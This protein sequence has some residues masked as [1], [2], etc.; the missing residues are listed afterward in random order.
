MRQTW[1]IRWI[2]RIWRIRRTRRIRRIQWIRRIA[3]A[4]FFKGFL[5]FIYS[6]TKIYYQVLT[7]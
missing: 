1:R 2:Q 4:I 6:A 3:W 5:S 7:V